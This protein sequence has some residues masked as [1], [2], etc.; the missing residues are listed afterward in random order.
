M[1]VRILA[2]GLALGLAT[3]CA[4]AGTAHIAHGEALTTGNTPY[5]EFFA[6][7]RD[8]WNEA[9]AAQG[10]EET[11]HAALLKALGLQPMTA[12]A[13]VLDES[14]AR[15]HKLQDKGVLLHLEIT[16]DPRLVRSKADAGDDALLKAFEEAA[17]ASLE[18]RK[19]LA[20][21]A[22]RA[23]A[24]DKRRVDLRAQAPDT[25]RADG[26]AKL[27]EVIRE[28]E[29]AQGVLDNAAAKANHAA[30]AASRF[31]VELAQALETGAGEA[32]FK[33][34]KG[35]KRPAF[36][37]A[38]PPPVAVAAAPAA[39]APAPAPKPAAPA[40]KPAAAPAPKPAAPPPPKKPKGGDDFEP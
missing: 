9:E 14:A 23:S 29:A 10:D 8:V 18:M 2:A 6:A 19:R 15:A 38:A 32:S 17:R 37:V 3:G 30:G 21:L 39:P 4:A 7:L 33:L 28:L 26:Q 35:A 22:A 5:D 1:A 34:A 31:V 24:L 20:S 11:S 25:F 12:A 16:P 27:D 40:P 13:Q 36:S